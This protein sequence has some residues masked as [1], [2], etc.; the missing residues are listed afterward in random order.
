[1]HFIKLFSPACVCVCLRLC[2]SIKLPNTDPVETIQYLEK[3][4]H[5]KTA[6]LY[7]FS[8]SFGFFVGFSG[9]FQFNIIIYAKLKDV[10][11]NVDG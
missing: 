1:M 3:K 8:R 4:I 11:F 2:M 5:A 7:P 10:V 6:S 9:I